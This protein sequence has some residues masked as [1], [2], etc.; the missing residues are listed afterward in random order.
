MVIMT[1]KIELQIWII[2]KVVK[3]VYYNI[4]TTSQLLWKQNWYPSGIYTP[5]WFGTLGQL[6]IDFYRSIILAFEQWLDIVSR[7]WL[8]ELIFDWLFKLSSWD[9]ESQGSQGDSLKAITIRIYILFILCSEG[10]RQYT[11]SIGI[12]K[13]VY[14][15]SL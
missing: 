4:T 8:H 5:L 9:G 11:W 10:F 2:C 6:T 12:T 13:I 15:L 7:I 1:M 3:I 14:L